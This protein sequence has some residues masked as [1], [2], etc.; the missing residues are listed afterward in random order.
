MPITLN[1]ISSSNFQEICFL[2]ENKRSV[3]KFQSHEGN[4][5]HLQSY[6]SNAKRDWVFAEKG[7]VPSEQD[8]IYYKDRKHVIQDKKSW[9]EDHVDRRIQLFYQQAILCYNT[10][11]I[12]EAEGAEDQIGQGSNLISHGVRLHQTQA[13]HS[14]TLPCL[15]AYPK[16]E[17][18][19]KITDKKFVFLKHSHFYLQ[20]NATVELPIEVNQVDTKLDGKTDE[21]KLRGA[22][23]KILNDTAEGKVNPTV[24]TKSFFTVFKN[25]LNKMIEANGAENPDSIVLN[26]YLE[27][28]KAVETNLQDK[29]EI[30]DQI[31]GVVIP[32]NANNLR[33]L[34]YKRRYQWIQQSQF[35]ESQIAKKIFQSQRRMSGNRTTSTKN[36][37]YRLRYILLKNTTNEAQRK[38]LERLFCCTFE[39]IQKH[40]ATNQDR[41]RSGVVEKIEAFERK[42]VGEIETLMEVLKEFMCE[43]KKMETAYHADLFKGLRKEYK[44]WTQKNFV[45]EFK[46]HFSK[47]A[48]SPA[49]VSRL[50]QPSRVDPI[51]EAYKTPQNQRRKVM[52]LEK[53]QH[54]A[55]AFGVDAGVFLTGSLISDF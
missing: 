54:I 25:R 34:V 44:G 35:I 1:S 31:L 28:L 50:E 47:E 11:F 33:D 24:A 21:E 52:T 9:I 10:P 32:E 19:G 12:F 39:Q 40:K 30:F 23:L 16:D 6:N 48:M 3:T 8:I 37:D 45:R 27:R 53:V 22:A 18:G 42:N 38:F 5:A 20:Q 51:K 55:M 7:K 29:S 43:L 13:A 14:S 49:M 2:P 4:K 36:V 46:S 17:N 15:Y 26:I 41:L